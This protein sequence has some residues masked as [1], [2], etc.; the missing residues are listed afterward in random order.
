MYCIANMR[1]A[2][3]DIHGCFETFRTMVEE[4]IQLKQ[5]DELYLLG[6]YVD[7][8]P[9]SKAVLDY[10]ENLRE[11]GYAISLLRGNHDQMLLDAYNHASPLATDQWLYNGGKSTLD[12]YGITRIE[13]MP[14]EHIRLLEHSVFFKELDDY[15]L[16]HAGFNLQS[17]NWQEDTYA[18][19][20]DREEMWDAAALKNKPII[21]GHTPTPVTQTEED[22]R[23]NK[24]VISIDTGCVYTQYTNMGHL[25]CLCLDDQTLITIANLEVP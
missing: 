6:D 3:A 14:Q 15:W 4:H 9:D 18:M 16:V 1:Y 13:D 24:P 11:Q 10:I 20:W 8:G 12:S 2:I 23:R 7:R 21:H 22:I 5:T 19:L 25:T 17:T